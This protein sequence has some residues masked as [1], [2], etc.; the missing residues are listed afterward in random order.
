MSLGGIAGKLASKLIRKIDIQ[1]YR[2]NTALCKKTI[3]G[4]A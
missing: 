1:S 3:A 4:F 2:A